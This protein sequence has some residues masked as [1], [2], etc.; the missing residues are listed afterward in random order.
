MCD[1]ECVMLSVRYPVCDIQCVILIVL[2]DIT[3]VDYPFNVV[4]VWGNILPVPLIS[5]GN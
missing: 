3:F 5:P 4:P 2:S 1:V